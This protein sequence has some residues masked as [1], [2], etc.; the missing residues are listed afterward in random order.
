MACISNYYR[1]LYRRQN[2]V[3]DKQAVK[4]TLAS[5]I[6]EFFHLFSGTVKFL[7]TIIHPYYH[8][9]QN[10]LK[11]QS[12][13]KFVFLLPIFIFQEQAFVDI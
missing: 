5:S 10:F 13:W 7:R 4:F 2:L 12:I 9:Q 1:A 3:V 8:L 6:L 11:V